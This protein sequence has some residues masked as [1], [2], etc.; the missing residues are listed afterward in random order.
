MAVQVACIGVHVVLLILASTAFTIITAPL[1]H[2]S[3]NWNYFAYAHQDGW[4]YVYKSDY[5]LAQVLAYLLAYGSGVVVYPWQTR[6]R[7]LAVPATLLCLAGVISFVIELSHWFFDHNLSWIASFPVVV[8]PIAV[9]TVISLWL[10]RA[11]DVE[12]NG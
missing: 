12:E 10:R 3:F 5:S 9:W 4:G 2:S 6:P 7:F 8:L 1:G 11:G